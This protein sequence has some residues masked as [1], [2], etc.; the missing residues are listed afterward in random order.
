MSI[1]SFTFNILI[2]FDK[3][4]IGIYNIILT[5]LQNSILSIV[6]TYAVEIYHTKERNIAVYL[7]NLGLCSGGAISQSLTINIIQAG[8]NIYIIYSIFKLLT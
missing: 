1:L 7:L 5:L 4:Q 8:M 2:I 6:H 3:T